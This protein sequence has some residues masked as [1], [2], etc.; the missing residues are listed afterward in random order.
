[1]RKVV[2][3]AVANATDW[4]PRSAVDVA[5]VAKTTTYAMVAGDT[6]IL[7]NTASGGFTV[8]LPTA[9]GATRAYTVKKIAAANTLTVAS[10]SGTIDGAATVT[11]VVQYESITVVSDGTNWFVV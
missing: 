3:A 8:T 5:A 4:L 9:V 7:G 2:G 6:V 1:M 10:A 11:I